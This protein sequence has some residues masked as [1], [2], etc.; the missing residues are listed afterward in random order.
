[1]SGSP[2]CFDLLDVHVVAGR[3]DA[4]AVRWADGSWTYARLLEEVAAFGGVLRHCGVTPGDRVDL[5]LPESVELVVAVLACA[6]IGAEHT[7]GAGEAAVLVT[8]SRAGGQDAPV[9]L[10]KQRPG[11]ARELVEGR[12]YDWDVVL[13]AGRTDPAPQAEGAVVTPYDERTRALLAPLLEGT[14]LSLDPARPPVP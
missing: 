2:T 14:T 10:V 3:A 11:A 9:V 6:R 12:D 8:D 7:Y 1:M 13:R 4:E 5:L